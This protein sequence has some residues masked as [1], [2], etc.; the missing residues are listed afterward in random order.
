[1]SVM[2]LPVKDRPGD[3]TTKVSAHS[4]AFCYLALIFF[5]IAR[6]CLVSRS[7]ALIM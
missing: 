5:R 4:S 1:V 3:I 7:C 2:D 6:F